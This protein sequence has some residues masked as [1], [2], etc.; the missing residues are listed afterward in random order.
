MNPSK[1]PLVLIPEAPFAAATEAI[2]R[3]AIVAYPTETFY[4]LGVDPSSKTAIERL[5]AV[6][7]RS[8]GNPVSVLVSGAEMLDGLV[9]DIPDV[10]RKLMDRLWPGPLTILFPAHPSVPEALTGGTSMI[11]VRVSSSPVCAKLVAAIGGPVTTTSANPSGSPP[12][13]SA[14]E[15]RGYFGSSIDV[16]IDGGRC[17]AGRPSTVVDVSGADG[18]EVT[19]I[20]EGVITWEEIEVALV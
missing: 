1:K 20:R 9:A 3:G 12:A 2:R 6:K 8:P 10:A 5:F 15:V 17:E 18:P 4:G 14:D 19:I 16:L 7:G 11:G 13:A